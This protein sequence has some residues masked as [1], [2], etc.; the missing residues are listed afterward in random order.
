[1]A[2][3]LFTKVLRSRRRDRVREAPEASNSVVDLIRRYQEG[4]G[5]ERL[6]LW[7]QHRDLREEFDSLTPMFASSAAEK[8]EPGRG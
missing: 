1:M 6:H 5:L 4:D 3:T 2:F 7:L 8:G